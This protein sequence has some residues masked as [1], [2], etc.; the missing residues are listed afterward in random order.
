MTDII[1]G[2]EEGTELH[3]VRVPKGM[4][5]S[6]LG[7]IANSQGYRVFGEPARGQVTAASLRKAAEKDAKAR[8][9]EQPFALRAGRK[10]DGG[11]GVPVTEFGPGYP[12][13][14]LGNPYVR[15]WVQHHRDTTFD[16]D[17]EVYLCRDADRPALGADYDPRDWRGL[18]L[19]AEDAKTY[20][21]VE[22]EMAGA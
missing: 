22:A 21:A 4:T 13:M 20:D 14:A 6:E 5:A 9:G 12:V 11:P 16:R 7:D 17:A 8:E 2:D 3:I 18:R 10:D 19:S 1:I 15:E